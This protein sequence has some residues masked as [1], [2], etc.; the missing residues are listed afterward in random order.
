MFFPNPFKLNMDFSSKLKYVRSL[1]FLCIFCICISTASALES[2]SAESPRSHPSLLQRFWN[3]GC[4]FSGVVSRVRRSTDNPPTPEPNFNDPE[5]L[6]NYLYPLANVG[7]EESQRSAPGTGT[8]SISSWLEDLMEL[9]HS[10]C[11]HRREKRSTKRRA[12]AANGNG[13]T[14]RGKKIE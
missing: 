3:I 12:R 10:E 6:F 9:W 11:Q 7:D 2:E 13:N 8:H 14:G 1:Q 5:E 4:E